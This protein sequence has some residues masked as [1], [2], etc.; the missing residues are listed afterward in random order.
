[1]NSLE[2]ELILG[3]AK[4]IRALKIRI[5]EL[6]ELYEERKKERGMMKRGEYIVVREV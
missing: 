4:E 1:M 6:E 5:R 3:Q 2:R